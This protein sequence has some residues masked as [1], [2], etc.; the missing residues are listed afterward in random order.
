VAI[1]PPS[2]VVLGVLRAAQPARQQAA[3]ERLARLGLQNDAPQAGGGMATAS[4]APSANALPLGPASAASMRQ[5]PASASADPFVQFEAMALQTFLQSM[6]PKD[7][8]SVF[9]KGT[10][11]EIWKSMLAERLAHELARSGGIG[12]ARTIA[13]DAMHPVRTGAPVASLLSTLK[14]VAEDAPAVGASE[15]TPSPDEIEHA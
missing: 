2:D 5:Q 8:T 6:M 10:A 15:P 12:I 4:A 1:N 3:V 7:A 14:P 13:A 9:G 11:G